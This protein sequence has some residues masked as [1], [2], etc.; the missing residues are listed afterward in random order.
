[1]LVYGYLFSTKIHR[2]N[3]LKRKVFRNVKCFN[4]N[5]VVSFLSVR[6]STAL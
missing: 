4:K 3:R 6:T 1:M 5:N 2:N